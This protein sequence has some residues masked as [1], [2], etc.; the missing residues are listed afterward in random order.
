[1]K[2]TFNKG[3]A[4]LIFIERI[5]KH[6]FYRDMLY[7]I[8]DALDCAVEDICFLDD[9]SNGGNKGDGLKALSKALIQAKKRNKVLV[10]LALSKNDH[11]KLYH[12][13]VNTNLLKPIAKWDNWFV[14][15]DYKKRNTFDPQG[16]GKYN[17]A[18]FV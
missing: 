5:N 14:D 2:V 11:K 7:N 10:L 18:D 1:M 4:N 16:E 13:Y 8:G 6:D 15:K 12:W 3:S 9:L 17:H